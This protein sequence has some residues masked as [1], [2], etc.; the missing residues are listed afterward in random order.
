[1][2][3]RQYPSVNRVKRL[4]FIFFTGL[5]LL[6]SRFGRYI[7][8]RERANQRRSPLQKP[9][10]AFRQQGNSLLLSG[11]IVLVL[12]GSA[13]GFGGRRACDRTAGIG[14]AVLRMG[15]CK[16]CLHG[17]DCLQ[18][19]RLLPRLLCCHRQRSTASAVFTAPL[20]LT[21]PHR[22]TDCD[23]LDSPMHGG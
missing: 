11:F 10:D 13:E 2:L 22:P 8:L 1:M 12:S 20:M 7:G 3:T 4:Y 9:V 17:S 15:S 6:D 14:S 23:N 19:S 21:S 5:L 16:Q 18:S